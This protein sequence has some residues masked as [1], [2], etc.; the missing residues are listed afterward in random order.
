MLTLTL[1]ARSRRV[2]LA[3]NFLLASLWGL[4]VWSHLRAFAVSKDYALIAFGLSETLQAF[5][6][7]IRRSPKTVSLDPFDWLIAGGGTLV[8]LFLRPGGFVLFPYGSLLVILAVVVQIIA[9]LSLNRSFALVAAKRVVKVGGLYRVVRH[10]MYAS[11]IFLYGGYLL[12]NASVINIFLVVLAFVFLF[13]RL[14]EEEKHLSEDLA[15]RVYKERVRWRLI[16][17]VY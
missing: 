5:F 8:P 10:P 16:P 14:V 15:Y 1:L 17:F 2:N 13:L 9:L 6:F 12:F 11:Y 4:F 7:L 3:I